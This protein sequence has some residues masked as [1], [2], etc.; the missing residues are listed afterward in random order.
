MKRAVISAIWGLLLCVPAAFGQAQ[1]DASRPGREYVGSWY[2]FL[3][4]VTGEAS[5]CRSAARVCRFANVR[6]VAQS[7]NRRTA[8]SG[9]PS[10]S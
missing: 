8:R 6:D 4:R 5:V 1:K 2:T 10:L 3:S 7:V 9:K